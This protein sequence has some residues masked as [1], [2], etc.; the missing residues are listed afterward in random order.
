M[1]TGLDKPP[2]VPV[3]ELSAD[4]LLDAWASHRNDLYG[5][6]AAEEG[7]RR[8]YEHRARSS[9]TVSALLSM[10]RLQ[11]TPGPKQS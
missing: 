11:P 8:V 5:V 7:M 3:A 1:S 4:E 6:M 9:E 2:I 10:R